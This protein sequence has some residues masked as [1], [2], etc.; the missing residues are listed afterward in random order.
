MG[1]QVVEIQWK[2]LI[3]RSGWPFF[4]DNGRK[5]EGWKHNL[6]LSFLLLGFRQN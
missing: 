1:Q 2:I 6:G 5:R 3:K 4:M